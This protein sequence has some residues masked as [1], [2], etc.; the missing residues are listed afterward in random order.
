MIVHILPWRNQ[1]PWSEGYDV[2]VSICRLAFVIAEARADLLTRCAPLIS[3]S[4]RPAPRSLIYLLNILLGLVLFAP[5][6]GALTF[7]KYYPQSNAMKTRVLFSS[8]RECERGKTPKANCLH[9]DSAI[10]IVNY[11][12]ESI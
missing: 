7:R 10:F 9:S 11:G 3:S 4:A 8:G 1:I 6:L 2:R 12:V 5:L